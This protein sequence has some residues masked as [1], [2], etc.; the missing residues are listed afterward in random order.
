MYSHC[1]AVVLVLHNTH[2]TKN[3]DRLYFI[4][5]I[6]RITVVIHPAGIPLDGFTCIAHPGQ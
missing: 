1:S 4:N 2:N 3:A 6:V 5:T